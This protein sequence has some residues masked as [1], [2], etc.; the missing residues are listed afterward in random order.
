MRRS[1]R[2]GRAQLAVEVGRVR[3]PV[4]GG[5]HGLQL[6]LQQGQA[7]LQDADAVVGAAHL[8]GAF[9][10]ERLGHVATGPGEAVDF[11]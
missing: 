10:S 9:L 4:E 3:D 11:A 5:L 2:R 1:A 8:P 6:L 7:P